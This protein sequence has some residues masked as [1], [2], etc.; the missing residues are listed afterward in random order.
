MFSDTL[1]EFD[2]SE[3]SVVN[4]MEEYAAAEKPEYINWGAAD[5]Q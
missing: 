2:Q 5:D 3:E 4:L 1:E